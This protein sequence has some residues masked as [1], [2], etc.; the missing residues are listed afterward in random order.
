MAVTSRPVPEM[1]PAVTVLLN[2]PRALPIAMTCWP[3]LMVLESPK[4]A[5]ERLSLSGI[6]MKA[7]SFSGSAATSS[8]PEKVE[9][10]AKT[11]EILL[12][13]FMTCLLVIIKPSFDTI[14]P[15]PAALEVEL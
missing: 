1:I 14:T 10:S 15:V 12:A 7:R 11:T 3:T 8:A 4:V 5:G 13:P 6:L 9:P 2:T